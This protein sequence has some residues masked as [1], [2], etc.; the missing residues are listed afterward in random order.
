MDFDT[1]ENV[2]QMPE[3]LTLIGAS[4]PMMR[5]RFPGAM[6]RSAAVL[7]LIEV[8][9]RRVVAGAWVRAR[10]DPT[11]A[12]MAIRTAAAYND[13]NVRSAFAF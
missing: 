8:K 5:D 3:I 13:E 9:N 7:A 12:D 11:Y 1:A 2:P 4:V 6:D 10:T